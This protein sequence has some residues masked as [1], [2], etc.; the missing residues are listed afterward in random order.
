[1]KKIDDSETNELNHKSFLKL[2]QEGSQ[3]F[4]RL[5]VGHSENMIYFNEN[6]F[7]NIVKESEYVKNAGFKHMRPD[8]NSRVIIHAK[9]KLTAEELAETEYSEWESAEKIRNYAESYNVWEPCFTH[10]WGH[11]KGLTILSEYKNS[12]GSL[13]YSSVDRNGEKA[14][15]KELNSLFYVGTYADGILELDK[16]RIYPLRLILEDLHNEFVKDPEKLVALEPIHEIEINAGVDSVGDYNSSMIETFRSYLISRYGDVQNINR[17]FG[18]DFKTRADIMPPTNTDASKAWDKYEGKYFDEWTLFTR[19]IIN[20]RLAEADREALLAGFA[21]EIICG[22]SI[23]EG[24]AIE[25]FLGEANTRI[26]PIDAMMNLGCSFGA[27]RYG[28][29]CENTTNFLKSAFAAGF[30]NST[31]GEYNSM[32]NNGELSYEQMLYVISHGAKFVNLIG[33]VHE[34]G[35][36]NDM[37]ALTR[38]AEEGTFRRGQT[39]G[40][41][42]SVPYDTGSKKYQIVEIG[43]DGETSG[44]LKSVDSEGKWTGDVYLTPFHAHIDVESFSLSTNVRSGAVAATI[45]DLNIGDVVELNFIGGC[46][47]KNGAKL[48]IDVY[49]NG[50]KNENL[51]GVL[52]LSDGIKSYKYELSNHV[53]LGAI[54]IKTYFEC[55]NYKDITVKSFTGNIMRENVARVFFGDETAAFTKCGV[56]FDTIR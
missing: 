5:D 48:H 42:S 28:Y 34:R 40:V 17:L 26:S 56:F 13:R 3:T 35:N 38:I 52:N 11:T 54:K 12:D 46:K 51:S 20:K 18:T 43:G 30:R 2:Y 29:W 50:V 8:T 53:V 37:A 19:Q 44:L 41:K 10:R 4:T 47:S 15:Y 32:A 24:D 25:G 14:V 33:A 31:M 55:D 49:E 1:M 23:P 21:P 27:T 6:D 9:S 39:N 7:E 22:H 36:K 45:S 16:M